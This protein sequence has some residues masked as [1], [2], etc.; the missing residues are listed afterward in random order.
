MLVFLLSDGKKKDCNLYVAQ[1]AVI[2]YPLVYLSTDNCSSV[3]LFCCFFLRFLSF[4]PSILCLIQFVAFHFGT[5]KKTLSTTFQVLFLSV[6]V[7]T[8]IQSTKS[9]ILKVK[10][11]WMC[12]HI[13]LHKTMISWNDKYTA[14][15]KN[16]IFFTSILVPLSVFLFFTM[17]LS[18]FILCTSTIRSMCVALYIYTMGLTTYDLIILLFFSFSHIWK[19]HARSHTHISI[20]KYI[21]RCARE[22]LC[23]FGL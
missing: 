6:V 22:F 9:P 10:S 3:V 12:I 23:Q 15:Q 8:H 5:E 16:R 2:W 21:E 17:I 7:V 1:F 19:V 13:S 11:A 4:F 14:E 20:D 18:I